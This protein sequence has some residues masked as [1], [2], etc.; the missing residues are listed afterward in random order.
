MSVFQEIQE[1]E[2]MK[3]NIRETVVAITEDAM[4]HLKAEELATVLMKIA[5]DRA[6]NSKYG[7]PDE[8]L[9]PRRAVTWIEPAIESLKRV[10]DMH[11]LS[12]ED[13]ERQI[14]DRNLTANTRDLHYDQNI[15]AK[16]GTLLSEK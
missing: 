2:Q 14:A 13:L 12:W 10:R 4:R 15:Y 1:K 11:L 9:N 6:S 3:R 7:Q 16:D 5:L 8:I